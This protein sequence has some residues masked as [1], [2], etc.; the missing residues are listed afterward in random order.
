M[1][2]NDAWALRGRIAGRR[3]ACKPGRPLAAACPPSLRSRGRRCSQAEPAAGFGREPIQ[4]QP[5]HALLSSGSG[6]LQP[7]L[8]VPDLQRRNAKAS[9]FGRVAA[10]DTSKGSVA[11][12]HG[13]AKAP[14]LLCQ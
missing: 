8:A 4:Q 7:G 9:G 6:T 12:P 2:W 3:R 11:L 13:N 5:E 10:E 1:Q 14:Y